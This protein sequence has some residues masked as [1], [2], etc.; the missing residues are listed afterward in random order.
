MTLEQF[1][2]LDYDLG[3]EI[4][5][6]VEVTLRHAGHILGAAIVEHDMRDDRTS[7]RLVF[8]GDLGYKDAPLMRPPRVSAASSC[9]TC[10]SRRARSSSARWARMASR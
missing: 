5:P 10:P 3:R 1:V 7:F 4:V 2:E 8:S 9:P 6:G